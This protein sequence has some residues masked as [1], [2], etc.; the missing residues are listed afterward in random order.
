M[1][2]GKQGPLFTAPRQPWGLMTPFQALLGMPPQPLAVFSHNPAD[3]RLLGLRRQQAFQATARTRP[4]SNLA[5]GH[6]RARLCLCA[7]REMAQAAAPTAGPFPEQQHSSHLIQAQLGPSGEK[8]QLPSHQ[9]HSAL[10][11]PKTMAAPGP[12][13]R[14]QAQDPFQP[15][16]LLQ[17]P[18]RGRVRSAVWRANVLKGLFS[19]L[20]P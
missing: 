2:A 18:P 11:G 10:F 14:W 16:L 12:P 13:A 3:S 8:A 19:W 4:A 6:V 20:P 15:L 7:D 5:S 17:K 9:L 1:G